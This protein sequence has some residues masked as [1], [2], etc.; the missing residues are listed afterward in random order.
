MLLALLLGF[1]VAL[2]GDGTESTFAEFPREEFVRLAD[3][4][5]AHLPGER[6]LDRSKKEA[7]LVE[8]ATRVRHH[9]DDA[10]LKSALRV[11]GQPAKAGSPQD[12]QWPAPLQCLA[13]RRSPRTTLF[14]V[15]TKEALPLLPGV[16]LDA[17][18]DGFLRDHFTNTKQRMDTE[19]AGILA[20]VAHKFSAARIEIVSGYRSPKYNLMLRKKGHEVA[21][22]SQHPEG[23]A[24]D[25]RVRGVPTKKLVA[26][27]RS[28]RKG[29]VGYY[30]RSQFVHC[31]TARVRY[32]AGS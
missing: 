13:C 7:W 30:P 31:D 20:A 21:K 3:E 28:L 32:W 4:R 26:F 18:I 9:L 16:T 2:A 5:D 17:H 8:K 14:N 11:A 23:T 10:S 24:V 25:F 19:L 6:T 15:W 29:G 12:V 1:H 22:D 27:V